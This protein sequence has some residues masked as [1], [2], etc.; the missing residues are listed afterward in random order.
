MGPDETVE[1]GDR[2][3]GQLDPRHV[4]EV[5]QV[6]RA[7]GPRLTESQSRALERA[8]D[9]VE[10]CDDVRGV[11]R[12]VVQSLREER[13]SQAPLVDARPLGELRKLRGA[14]PIEGDVEPP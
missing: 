13:S 2:G 12:R 14:L 11:G 3:G 6:D 4:L 5:A 1:V 9:A 7:S 8:G 10:Q